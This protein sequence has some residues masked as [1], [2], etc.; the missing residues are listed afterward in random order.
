ML[1]V[2]DFGTN[3]H[4]AE[5]GEFGVCYVRHGK[6]MKGSPPKRRS[7]LT[8]WPWIVEHNYAARAA[9]I[10]IYG[11]AW[12]SVCPSFR[13]YARLGCRDAS[14]AVTCALTCSGRASRCF[15]VDAVTGSKSPPS[16]TSA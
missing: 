9:T 12:P 7:V 15:G 14:S 3:P 16:R 5:F 4:A 10:T 13:P 6:A 1:D 2:A 8:V 11:R